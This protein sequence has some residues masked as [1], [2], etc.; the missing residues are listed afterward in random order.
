MDRSPL[1]RRDRVPGVREH[2]LP[3]AEIDAG[4]A[5]WIKS[6]GF[7]VVPGRRRQAYTDSR[8]ARKR[9]PRSSLLSIGEVLRAKRCCGL[10]GH[11]MEIVGLLRLPRP[12]VAQKTS[13]GAL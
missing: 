8:C 3:I 5:S 7:L 12:A 6:H 10:D 9:I 13:P 2:S 4:Q 11:C 1:L